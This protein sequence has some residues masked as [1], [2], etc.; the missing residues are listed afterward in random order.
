MV[1]LGEGLAEEME[2]DLVGEDMEEVEGSWPPRECPL[3][4]RCRMEDRSVCVCAHMRACICVC[5]LAILLA[6]NHYVIL[7]HCT[8][9]PT[10]IPARWESGPEH[11][12][13][14]CGHDLQCY[15]YW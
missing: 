10:S 14:Y 6:V 12:S 11:P 8:P 2:V 13:S 4:L 1:D 3:P 15:P 7:I 9:I 5:C